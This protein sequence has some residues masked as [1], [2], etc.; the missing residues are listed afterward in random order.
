M[1]SCAAGQ[2]FH[3]LITCG[4]AR[5]EFSLCLGSMPVAFNRFCAIVALPGY[6]RN[7]RRLQDFTDFGHCPALEETHQY[8]AVRNH[9]RS[10]EQL[11]G[12]KRSAILVTRVKSGL[13]NQQSIPL[14]S[15]ECSSHLINN[16]LDD[17]ILGY[18]LQ[19]G[20]PKVTAREVLQISSWKVFSQQC[21]A[22]LFHAKNIRGKKKT[23]DWWARYRCHS[24][25]CSQDVCIH[26]TSWSKERS[27]LAPQQKLA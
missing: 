25:S 9:E 11:S 2:T 12:T 15:V 26:H 13:T 22:H 7:K 3:A 16:R 23:P 24:K 20:V 10:K 14:G 4:R 17:W 18:F 5:S 21:N 6:R 8:E 19:N 27:P 1:S